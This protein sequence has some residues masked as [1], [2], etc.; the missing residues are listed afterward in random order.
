M[1]VRATIATTAVL[2]AVPTMADARGAARTVRRQ[3][4]HHG[5]AGC[6]DQSLNGI[7]VSPVDGNVY[8]ASVGGDEVTVHDTQ[9]G[10]LPDRIGP[11]RGVRG[12][13]DLFITDDGTIYWTEILTGFVGMLKP[14]GTFEREFV[15]PG[16]NP[17]TMSD[18]GRLFVGRLFFGSGLYELDKDF[19]G[20][21]VLL[22]GNLNINASDFGPDGYLYAPAQFT[23]EIVKIDVDA[24]VPVGATTIASGFRAPT[25]AKFN[26]QGELHVGDLAEGQVV[27]LDVASGD[28]EVLI[29]IEGTIDNIAFGADD[30][31]YAAA[32]SDNQIVWI[33]V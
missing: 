10:K 7:S 12:P 30:R 14:G 21:P 5:G 4:G 33:R 6:G 3:A 26:S 28:R 18:D 9:N 17:I 15:G 11:E 25:A 8:V 20:A 1:R 2:L 31:L 22:D 29:D 19:V 32:G 23:G 27:K 13:D 24:P 16:V